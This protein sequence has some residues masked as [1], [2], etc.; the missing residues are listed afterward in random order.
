VALRPTNDFEDRLGDALEALLGEG[1]SSIGQLAEGLNDLNVRSPDGR[2]WTETNLGTMLHGLA[3]GAADA[4]APPRAATPLETTVTEPFPP[5]PRT[6]EDLLATGLRNLWYVVARSN[7]VSDRPYAITRFGLHL[8]LWRGSDGNVRA[9]EDYCPHRG[10]PLSLGQAVGDEIR[11]SYHGFHVS[12]EGVI[13]QTPP[14]PN[15]SLVGQRAI[16]AYPCREYAGAILLYYGAVTARDVPEPCVPPDLRSAEWS[17]F[18]YTAEWACNWQMALDNRVDPMHG[19]YLHAG[20]FTLSYG[21]QQA[22]LEIEVTPTGFETKRDNQRGVN[23]DWHKVDLHPG[24]L[25]W[26]R[27]E[28]PYPKSVGGGSFFIDGHATPIDER[29]TYVAFFRSQRSTGWKRDV[30][31]FLY[32]NRLDRRHQAVVEQDRV[33]LES[34]PLAARKR[35]MLIQSDIAV[36]RLRRLMREE[37]QRQMQALTGTPVAKEDVSVPG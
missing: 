29:H 20:S 32:K 36:G 15:C 5:V 35:E 30:W 7:D 4:L 16:E 2:A 19:S 3:E 28:I 23:I 13:T 25:L 12:G 6:A 24:N 33:V 22:K 14:T 18:L 8:V 17:T 9:T 26:V 37:A 10:A 21:L 34:I 11:C 1:A 27:T 31:R